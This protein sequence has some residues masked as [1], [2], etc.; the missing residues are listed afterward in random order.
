MGNGEL[1]PLPLAMQPK[2]VRAYIGGI[3]TVEA[4][5]GNHQARLGLSY[6]DQ[7]HLDVSLCPNLFELTAMRYTG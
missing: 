1:P 5:T 4:I 3:F 6:P 7:R 2:A